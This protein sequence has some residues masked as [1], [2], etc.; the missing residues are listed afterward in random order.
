MRVS[1]A[2]FVSDAG[3]TSPGGSLNI[4]PRPSETRIL[5][6]TLNGLGHPFRVRSTHGQGLL[7]GQRIFVDSAILHNDKKV[8]AGVFDELEIFQWIAIDQHQVSE[9][10]PPPQH[11]ACRDKD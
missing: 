8:L 11:Q 5:A 3:D 6:F 10:A 2:G 1:G 7:F 9:C 4:L